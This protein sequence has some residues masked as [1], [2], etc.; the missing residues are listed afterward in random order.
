MEEEMQKKA[1]L[2]CKSVSPGMFSDE[3]TIVLDRFNGQEESFFVPEKK[4]I[5]NRLQVLVENKES[6]SWATL[7]T[8]QP[9][10]IPINKSCI[11]YK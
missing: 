3:L 4:V 10:L 5:G 2:D 9:F 6:I 8:E 11:H 7:P 1:W